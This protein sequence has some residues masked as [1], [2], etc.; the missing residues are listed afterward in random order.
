[1]FTPDV[2]VALAIAVRTSYW[3]MP[4]KDD[5]KYDPYLELWHIVKCLGGKEAVML[6][7]EDPD[8]AMKKYVA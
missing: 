8:E 2:K 7:K 4:P 3:H 6:L 1:M 5:T